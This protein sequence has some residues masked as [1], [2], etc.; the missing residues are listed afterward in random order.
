MLALRLGINTVLKLAAG[1]YFVLVSLYC[2][3]AYLPYTFCAFIK[4]PPYPWMPW[5]AHHQA[6]LYWLSV[7]A[8]VA[9]TGPERWLS[10]RWFADRRV[11]GHNRGRNWLGIGLL[12][13]GG[14]YLTLHPF[15]PS[16]QNNNAP[17][18]WGFI[19]LLPLAGVCCVDLI[20]NRPAQRGSANGADADSGARS[21]PFSS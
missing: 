12:A 16:L 17:F 14:I 6:L 3:L 18:V 9:A 13:A 21:L 15:L 1:T 7:I 4:T 8:L 2:L 11:G 20:G 10:E 19:S 5:L